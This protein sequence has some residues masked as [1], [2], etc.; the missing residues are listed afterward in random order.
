MSPERLVAGAPPIP[1]MVK[2]AE[3]AA[4]R[5]AAQGANVLEIGSAWGF[6]TVLM[7]EV[8]RLVVSVDPHTMADTWQAFLWNLDRYGVLQRV[9]VVKGTSQDELP[10]MPAWGADGFF[11]VA[12]VDGLHTRWGAWFDLTWCRQL[13]RAGGIIAAHDYCVRWPGVLDAVDEVLAGLPAWRIQDLYL[14]VNE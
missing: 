14:A 7:A 11:D 9:M 1:T 5:Q 4:L 13:V 3:A 10:K 12:F 8:A 6:S 2:P